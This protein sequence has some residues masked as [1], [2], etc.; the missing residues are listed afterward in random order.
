MSGTELKPCPFC[1]GEAV[2]QT[3][4]SDEFGNDG[5]DVIECEKCLA[6]SHVEFGR[7][8]NLV[9]AWNTRAPVD[10]AALPEVQALIAGAFEAA[11]KLALPGERGSQVDPTEFAAGCRHNGLRLNAAIRAMPPADAIAAMDALIAEAVASALDSVTTL[12]RVISDIRAA[13]VGTKP[14]LSDL[15]KALVAWRDEAVKAERRLAPNWRHH[16][17]CQLCRQRLP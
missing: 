12:H 3:L 6:S 11:A 8:E 13:T 10:Y 16:Q 17:L 9:S 4:P 2:R 14:M 5:G 7:K 1:G 15:A